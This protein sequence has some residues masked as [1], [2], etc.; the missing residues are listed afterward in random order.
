MRYDTRQAPLRR[1]FTMLE[2]VAALGILATAATLAA[3]LGA[4]SLVERGRTQ[5]RLAATDAATNVLESARARPWSELT[6]EWAAGLRLPEYVVDRLHDPKLTV[7]ITPEPNRP[8]VKRVSVQ[9]QWDHSDT[10]PP[11][12]VTLVG[13][14]AERSAGGAS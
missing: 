9:I 1:G 7:Q 3:Q 14:F 6:P 8:H 5:C 13:L 12:T 11:E 2:A 4:W 10:R